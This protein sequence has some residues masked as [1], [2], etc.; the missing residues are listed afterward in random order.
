MDLVGLSG[1]MSWRKAVKSVFLRVDFLCS[2]KA[3]CK[4]H[5]RV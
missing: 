5:K 3:L 4:V 2:E 1:V